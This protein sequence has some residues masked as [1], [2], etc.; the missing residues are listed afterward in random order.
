MNN[1]FVITTDKSLIIYKADN[2]GSFEWL[3]KKSRKSTVTY[4]RHFIET[5]GLVLFQEFNHSA[6]V[7][8]KMFFKQIE[9][10]KIGWI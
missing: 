7:A 10:K 3:A 2:K 5:R 6:N 8:Q 1:I 4:F 9:E